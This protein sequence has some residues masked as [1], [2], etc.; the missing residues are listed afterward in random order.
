[1][2][3]AAARPRVGAAALKE[4]RTTI[5]QPTVRAHGGRIVKV[6]GDGC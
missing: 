2:C 6:T 3:F 5:L 4:R 1:M